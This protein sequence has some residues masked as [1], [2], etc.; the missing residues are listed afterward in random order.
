MYSVVE[1]DCTNSLLGDGL[2]KYFNLAAKLNGTSTFDI[3]RGDHWTK[4]KEMHV[5]IKVP[6]N[7]SKGMKN[8]ALAAEHLLYLD[9]SKDG[10]DLFKNNYAA[11]LEFLY[12]DVYDE[13]LFMGSAIDSEAV[14][15][16]CNRYD[17]LS[18]LLYVISSRGYIRP[19][20]ILLFLL[21]FLGIKDDG[22]VNYDLARDICIQH[23]LVS[24]LFLSDFNGIFILF[25]YFLT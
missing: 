24:D 19:Q 2:I 8:K 6:I 17:D 20:V 21:I 11:C 4:I 3:N 1:K 18:M 5:C 25:I 9:G 7:R 23:E 15:W 13:P 12:A 16:F 10:Y 14:H 22:T